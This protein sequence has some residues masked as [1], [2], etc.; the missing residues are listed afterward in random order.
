V[1]GLWADRVE[2]DGIGEFVAI[3][4]DRLAREFLSLLDTLEEAP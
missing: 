3:N 1:D 2:A 4:V